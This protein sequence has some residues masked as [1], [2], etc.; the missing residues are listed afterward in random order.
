MIVRPLY[1]AFFAMLSLCTFAQQNSAAVSCPATEKA[2]REVDL[3][4]TS[5]WSAVHGFHSGRVLLI[6]SGVVGASAVGTNAQAVS[7]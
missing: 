6:S 3:L 4:I 5:G 1:L 7:I 2:V